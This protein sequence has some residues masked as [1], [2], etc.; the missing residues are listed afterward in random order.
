MA[1]KGVSPMVPKQEIMLL[2]GTQPTPLLR[3]S[4]RSLTGKPLPRTRPAISQVQTMTSGSRFIIASW[5]LPRPDS[6]RPRM[7]SSR[8]M[9][10]FAV[11]SSCCSC[12]R[13]MRPR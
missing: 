4:G 1:P 2:V 6:C 3:R 5:W 12:R 13:A 11:A 9:R 7:A 8:S 10:R